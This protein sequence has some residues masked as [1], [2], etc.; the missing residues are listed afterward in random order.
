M[1]DDVLTELIN[2]A[3]L[4]NRD[5]MSARSKVLEARAQVG[6][7]RANFNPKVDFQ[8]KYENGRN[9]D[10]EDIDNKSYNEYSIGFDSSWEIDFF[11]K[12]KHLLK[13]AKAELESEASNLNN[14]WVR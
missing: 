6:I 14:A 8:S 7:T 10:I 11:G 1:G 2:E 9:S 13:S 5:L 3:F 12:N 4:K